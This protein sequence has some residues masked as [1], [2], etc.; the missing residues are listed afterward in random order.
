MRLLCTLS[1]L[2]VGANAVVCSSLDG[3]YC[4]AL[5]GRNAPFFA[6][7]LAADFRAA[8]PAPAR[9]APASNPKQTL[10]E[11]AQMLSAAIKAAQASLGHEDSQ[12]AAAPFDAQDL[13]IAASIAEAL[14]NRERQGSGVADGSAD[15]DDDELVMF[16]SWSQEGEFQHLEEDGG[17][18]D[19]LVDEDV[20]LEDAAVPEKKEAAR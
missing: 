2:A 16:T 9:S 8:L 3:P 18:G 17:D 5:N 12:G 15:S 10:A 4:S 7:A 20:S 19:G 6:R 11:L 14:L 13:A 1:L